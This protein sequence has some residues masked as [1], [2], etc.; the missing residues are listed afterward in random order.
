MSS[1]LNPT[2]TGPDSRAQNVLSTLAATGTPTRAVNVLTHFVKRDAEIRKAEYR[3][4]KEAQELQAAREVAVRELVGVVQDEVA[5]AEQ[6]R[7]D[8]LKAIDAE[9]ESAACG[10]AH[11][12]PGGR[13]RA[14]HL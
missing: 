3:E 7:A 11:Q 14:A 8:A 13:R 5:G 2:I 4:A 9:L 1:P 10:A 6:E 12:P